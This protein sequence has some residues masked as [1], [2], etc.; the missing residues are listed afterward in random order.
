MRDS[1]VK[2]TVRFGNLILVG[3]QKWDT[4][5]GASI[6]DFA[7][8]QDEAEAIADGA[9]GGSS[10]AKTARTFL[11]MFNGA[12]AQ[13]YRYVAAYSV[14]REVPG[15]AGRYEVL[16]DAK[17]AAKLCGIGSSL[18]YELSAAG[19]TPAPVKLNSKK[20]WVYEHL[21]IW[22]AHNCV[23]RDSAEW[24]EILRIHGGGRCR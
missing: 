15:D 7:R 2:G 21:K 4:N 14:T 6:A 16:V 5:R 1:Y 3:A 9:V 24:Q 19:R 17:T 20:L 13:S 12:A 10:A 22:A 8:S 23:S 11:T 18:W